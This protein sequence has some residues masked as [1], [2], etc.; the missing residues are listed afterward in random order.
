MK[1]PST[2]TCLALVFQKETGNKEL[3]YVQAII[4]D[5]VLSKTYLELRYL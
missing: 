3:N 2:G 5:T 4:N 1:K